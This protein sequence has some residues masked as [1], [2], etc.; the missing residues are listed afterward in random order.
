[1]YDDVDNAV[2]A[3]DAIGTVVY[4]D[5]SKAL[6]DAA[7][8][9]Y[10]ALSPEEQALVPAAKLDA[11]EAAEDTYQDL[12]DHAYADAAVQ[13]INAIGKVKYPTSAEAIKDARDA[14][15]ALTDVQKTIVGYDNYSKLVQAEGNLEAQKDLYFADKVKKLIIAIAPLEISDECKARIDAARAAYNDEKFTAEQRVL[16]TKDR[17]SVV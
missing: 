15:D 10:N 16:V 11:L 5:E 7:R 14:Y 3:I 1:M 17:K 13:L 8:N 4:T 6:I 12:L 2:K 9:A